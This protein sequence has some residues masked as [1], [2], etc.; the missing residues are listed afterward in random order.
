MTEVE[1]SDTNRKQMPHRKCVKPFFQN[2][3]ISSSGLL[4][5]FIPL[6]YTSVPRPSFFLFLLW[7]ILYPVL[8]SLIPN[9]WNSISCK[10]FSELFPD[11]LTRYHLPISLN[12]RSLL[13][14]L[15][16]IAI[17][18]LHSSQCYIHISNFASSK[19]NYSIYILRAQQKIFVIF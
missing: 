4:F 7:F 9:S 13:H 11:I 6:A 16:C 3:L 5:T 17:S 15:E 8:F 2:M 14:C 19:L 18:A 10:A 1:Y 12:L